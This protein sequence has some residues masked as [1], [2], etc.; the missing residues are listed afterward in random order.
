MSPQDWEHFIEQ[1]WSL[2]KKYF[3]EQNVEQ[4]DVNSWIPGINDLRSEFRT[5]KWFEE[6]KKSFKNV[7]GS[8][9]KESEIEDKCRRCFG[10]FAWSQVVETTLHSLIAAR[11]RNGGNQKISANVL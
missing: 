2:K 6:N 8:Q 10:N 3:T 5:R 1:Q 11:E 4:S 7:N 9:M